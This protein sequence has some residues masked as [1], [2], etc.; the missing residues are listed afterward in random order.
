M[1]K[2]KK[3]LETLEAN[4]SNWKEIE[5]KE[6][7]FQYN[8]YMR[9]FDVLGIDK[10]LFKNKK[11]KRISLAPTVVIDEIFKNFLENTEEKYNSYIGN[12]YF[13][14]LLAQRYPSRQYYETE[15]YE[16]VTSQL[17]IPILTNDKNS[18]CIDNKIIYPDS[19]DELFVES[20]SLFAVYNLGETDIVYLCVDL[21]SKKYFE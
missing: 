5:T 4:N 1:N 16:N 15:E 8:H 19:G 13:V 21:I 10:E 9:F 17:C 7:L 11:Y 18:F 2:I 20:G 6:D 12:C 3:I 14:K